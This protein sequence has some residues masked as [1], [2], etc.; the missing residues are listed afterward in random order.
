MGKM[1]KCKIT[2]VL[3]VKRSLYE[4]QGITDIKMQKKEELIGK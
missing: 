1:G 3:N 4:S 2:T